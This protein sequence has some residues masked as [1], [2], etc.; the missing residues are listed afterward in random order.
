MEGM[1]EK[2]SVTSLHWLRR[3]QRCWRRRSMQSGWSVK[4]FGEELVGQLVCG[5]VYIS[6]GSA[7]R[8]LCQDAS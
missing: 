6:S 2:E 4:M 3:E 5:N 1:D 7:T 8:A